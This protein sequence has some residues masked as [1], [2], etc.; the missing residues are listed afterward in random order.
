MRKPVVRYV[1]FAP[2][3]IRIWLAE[4]AHEENKW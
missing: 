1:R 3:F 4:P 2:S